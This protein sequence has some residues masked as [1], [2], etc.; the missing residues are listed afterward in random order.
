[1]VLASVVSNH[2]TATEADALNKTAGLLKYAPDRIAAG[3]CGKTAD[4]DE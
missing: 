4:N 2:Q 3:G 1:M